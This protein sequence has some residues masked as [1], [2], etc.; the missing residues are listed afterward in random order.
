MI[1]CY[2]LHC[3]YRERIPLAV[4]V[5]N[6]VLSWHTKEPQFS[7]CI[8]SRHLLSVINRFHEGVHAQ[9][10]VAERPLEILATVSFYHQGNTL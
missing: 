6:I 8:A 1:T 4:V 3:S 2:H 9:E 7:C 5:N 10:H